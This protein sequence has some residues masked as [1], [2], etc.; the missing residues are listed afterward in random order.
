M[1]NLT[2][3]ATMNSA[4]NQENETNAA[5]WCRYPIGNDLNAM[6][7]EVAN[8]AIV[9]FQIFVIYFRRISMPHP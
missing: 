2:F 1:K 5:E 9:N 8:Q 7:D 3:N 6:S 4:I